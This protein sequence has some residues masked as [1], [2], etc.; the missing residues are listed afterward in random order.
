MAA[1][2][3]C[4]VAAAD[5]SFVLAASADPIAIQ[6]PR[7]S[8]DHLG[9]SLRVR[10]RAGRRVGRMARRCTSRSREV[11]LGFCDRQ[12]RDRS[13]GS[14]QHQPGVHQVTEGA[15]QCHLA[16][17]QRSGS[18][19]SPMSGI[20]EGSAK[21]PTI[22]PAYAIAVARTLPSQSSQSRPRSSADIDCRAMRLAAAPPD[23]AS[24]TLTTVMCR[25]R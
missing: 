21:A 6:I 3:R 18:S 7:V 8:L 23:N 1:V 11:T 2:P 4:A 19:R 17:Q 5:S 25:P 12:E 20:P 14:H 15:K 24:A 22:V 9:G 13:E 16:E 10:L